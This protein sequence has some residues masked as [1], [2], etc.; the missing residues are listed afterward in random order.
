MPSHFIWQLRQHAA[1]VAFVNAMQS[2]WA[3][4]TTTGLHQY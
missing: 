3:A 2:L 1:S 4:H